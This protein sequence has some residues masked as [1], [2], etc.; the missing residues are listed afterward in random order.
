[1]PT[2]QNKSHPPCGEGFGQ[3]NGVPSCHGCHQEMEATGS[4]HVIFQS[5]ISQFPQTTHPVTRALPASFSYFIM[6]KYRLRMF[7]WIGST[8]PPLCT[9]IGE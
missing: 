9:K 4:V 6:A 2:K 3:G 5:T 8:A 1:V 7:P